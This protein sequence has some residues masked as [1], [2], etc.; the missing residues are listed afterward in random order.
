MAN[1]VICPGVTVQYVSMFS[2]PDVSNAEGVKIILCH[3]AE[4]R[5]LSVVGISTSNHMI[6]KGTA[7]TLYEERLDL[8]FDMFIHD[9]THFLQ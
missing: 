4:G 8:L 7:L 3:I 1:N 2:G 9:E 5:S 6:F